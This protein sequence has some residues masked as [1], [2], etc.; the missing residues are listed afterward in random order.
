MDRTGQGRRL[1]RPSRT[2]NEVRRG[3]D[4]EQGI[5]N[6]AGARDTTRSVGRNE[7]RGGRSSTEALGEGPLGLP[8]LPSPENAV[9]I[10]HLVAA[11]RAGMLGSSTGIERGAPKG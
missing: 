6:A 10:Q 5:G 4:V 11:V 8:R 7:R 2:P 9:A 1:A 3:A